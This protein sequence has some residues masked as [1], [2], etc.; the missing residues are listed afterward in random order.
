MTATR[1]LALAL[2][3]L[4]AALVAAGGAPGEESTSMPEVRFMTLDPGHFHASLVQKEMYPGVVSPRVD[5]YA[6]LGTDLVEHLG[7]ITAFNTRKD[8]PTSWQLEIHTGPDFFERM[9]TE[10]PGNVVVI[11]GRNSGKIDRIAASVHAGLNVLADKPWILKSAGPARARQGAGRGRREGRRRLRHHDRA[12]RGDE[13]SC[14]A[15]W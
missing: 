12:V 1:S 8:T 11:S 14:S 7:R 2:A 5:V 6:P 4:P 10:H 13:R 3:A 9:L 15:S